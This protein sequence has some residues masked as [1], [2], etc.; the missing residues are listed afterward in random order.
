MKLSDIL[1]GLIIFTLLVVTFPF[2]VAWGCIEVVKQKRS[3]R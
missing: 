1:W 3:G 2:L